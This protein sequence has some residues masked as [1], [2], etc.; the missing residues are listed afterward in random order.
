MRN[1]AERRARWK[2]LREVFCSQALGLGIPT[3]AARLDVHPATVYRLLTA[4][5]TPHKRTLER[6]ARLC[7]RRTDP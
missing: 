2:E 7:R 5:R 1:A 6:V 4:T 3:A